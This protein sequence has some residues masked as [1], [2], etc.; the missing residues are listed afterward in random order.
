MPLID[1]SLML[2][3]VLQASSAPQSKPYSSKPQPV[4][5]WDLSMDSSEANQEAKKLLGDCG[6]ARTQDVMNACFR[7]DFEAVDTQLNRDYHRYSKFLGTN[8]R[9]SLQ[10]IEWIWLQYRDMQ[11]KAVAAQVEGGSLQPT[12]FYACM[13]DVTQQRIRDMKSAYGEIGK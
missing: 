4:H 6:D 2:I 8:G 5:S 10:R 7:L 1:I 13:S 9:A 12:E 11:C 3:L